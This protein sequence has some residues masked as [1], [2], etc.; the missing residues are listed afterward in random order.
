M[1]MLQHGN[2]Y[3]LRARCYSRMAENNYHTRKTTEKTLDD[4]YRVVKSIDERV[5]EILDELSE[6]IRTRADKFSGLEGYDC[7]DHGY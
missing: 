7:D 1:H 6:D 4:L 5:E 2:V 3:K